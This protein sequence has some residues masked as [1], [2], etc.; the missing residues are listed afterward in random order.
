MPKRSL[1]GQKEFNRLNLA[2][3]KLLKGGRGK[4]RLHRGSGDPLLDRKSVV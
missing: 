4:P 2:V 3:E 1:P